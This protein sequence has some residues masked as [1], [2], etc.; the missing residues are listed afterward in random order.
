MAFVEKTATA[1]SDCRFCSVRSLLR[2]GA[3]NRSRT[4]TDVT[5]AD[6]KSALSTY[7]N[8]AAY[9]TAIG[10]SCGSISRELAER[11]NMEVVL[12][13]DWEKCGRCLSKNQE[14]SRIFEGSTSN[15]PQ[16]YESIVSA[17]S[18]IPAYAVIVA[19][20]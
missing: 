3:A 7:S 19:R 8:I 9:K 15:G 17:Y 6:F 11:R 1:I 4:G 5:P 10:V 16:D 2:R 14:K 13:I 20:I 18:S 12:E